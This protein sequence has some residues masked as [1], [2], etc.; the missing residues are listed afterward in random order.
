[1]RATYWAALAAGISYLLVVWFGW[2]GP[3][4]TIWKGAGV[5]LLALWAASEARNRGGWWI[6]A[7]LALGATGDVLLDAVG[8]KAGGV[9]F[10]AGH[11]LAAA[12]YWRHRSGRGGAVA[13]A[14][15][16]AT[17]AAS[18]LLSGDPGIAF[19]GACL[20]AMAAAAWGS[21]FPIRIGALLFVASDLLIFAKSGLPAE[22]PLTLLIWPF[23]FAAQALIAAGVVPALARTG[24]PR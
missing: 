4:V 14:I 2:S 13:L 8:L 10:L 6:A 21:R 3:A 24:E 1:V 19:Y 23:Y 22:S 17:P 9:A 11:L 20:G 16:V 5:G 15:L 18:Y 7:V 12:L